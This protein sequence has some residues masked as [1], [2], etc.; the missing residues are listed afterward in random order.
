MLT[1]QAADRFQVPPGNHRLFAETLLYSSDEIQLPV[2]TEI[3]ED[4]SKGERKEDTVNYR[5]SDLH[6]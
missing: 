2:P 6:L 5:T 1:S 3:W 4:D